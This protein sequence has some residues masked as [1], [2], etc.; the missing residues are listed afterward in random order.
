M[1]RGS[2]CDST[3]NRDCRQLISGSRRWDHYQKEV[4]DNQQRA[5]AIIN[6]VCGQIRP[7]EVKARIHTSSY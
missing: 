6:H 7:S 1:G 3:G 2:G 4:A 5:T